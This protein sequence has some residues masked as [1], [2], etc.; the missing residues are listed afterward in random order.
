M[1][2]PTNKVTI[3][4]RTA[5][6]VAT[7]HGRRIYRQNNGNILDAAADRW[8]CECRFELNGLGQNKQLLATGTSHLQWPRC[9]IIGIGGSGRNKRSAAMRTFELHESTLVDKF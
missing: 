2:F 1:D 9:R 3:P 7:V 4:N 8:R 5:T 6:T